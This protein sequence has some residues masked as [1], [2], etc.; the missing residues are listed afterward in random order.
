MKIIKKNNLLNDPPKMVHRSTFQ[1][2]GE[3]ESNKRFGF[4]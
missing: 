3:F 2:F 4:L 1:A